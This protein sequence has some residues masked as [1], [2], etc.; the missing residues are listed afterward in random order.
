MSEMSEMTNRPLAPVDWEAPVMS[1]EEAVVTAIVAARRVYNEVTWVSWADAWLLGRDRSSGAAQAAI[2]AATEDVDYSE[3]DPLTTYAALAARN[4]AIA[5]AWYR[6]GGRA[7]GICSVEETAR[8]AISV[9][10][11]VLERRAE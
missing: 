4:S 7:L 3:R 8:H 10:R 5:A 9:A 11:Y 1:V 6:T 2:A